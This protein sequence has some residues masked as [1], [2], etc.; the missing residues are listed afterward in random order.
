MTIVNII[1]LIKMHFNEQAIV[2]KS[3]QKRGLCIG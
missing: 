3:P 1:L 2:E